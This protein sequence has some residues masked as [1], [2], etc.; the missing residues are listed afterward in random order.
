V[1]SFLGKTAPSNCRLSCLEDK[2]SKNTRI[3]GYLYPGIF[4]NFRNF[5]KWKISEI[6]EISKSVPE[7]LKIQET[8]SWFIFELI[9][10]FGN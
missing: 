9:N 2:K 10:E 3:F 8:H 1:N 5:K 6:R 7:L 4:T